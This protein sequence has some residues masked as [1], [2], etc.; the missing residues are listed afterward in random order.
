MP[1]RRIA[2]SLTFLFYFSC[3]S[4]AGELRKLGINDLSWGPYN[5]TWTSPGG[6]T[7]TY[8]PR[9]YDNNAFADGLTLYGNDLITKG[10]RAD[11]RAYG[12]GLSTTNGTD[13]WTTAIQNAIDSGVKE[14]YVPDGI[15]S[16]SGINI[17]GKNG[18]KFYGNGK[19]SEIRWAGA[20]N[21][22]MLLIK[23]S[24]RVIVEDLWF[25]NTTDNDPSA[26]IESQIESTTIPAAVN[27]VTKNI[28]SRLTLGGTGANNIYRGIYYTYTAVDQNNDQATIYDVIARNYTV[29]GFSVQNNFTQSAGHRFWNCQFGPGPVAVEMAGSAPGGFTWIGGVT[30]NHTTAAFNIGAYLWP[31]TIDGLISE[32]DERLLVTA[33]SGPMPVIVRNVSYDA[34]SINADNVMISFQGSGP[35]ILE[36]NQ[37]GGYATGIIPLVVMHNS[38]SYSLSKLISIGNIWQIGTGASV[39]SPFTLDDVTQQSLISLGDMMAPVA[40]QVAEALPTVISGLTGITGAAG[41]KP[42]NLRGTFTVDNTAT[43]GV[44]TFG[45]AETN[46]S[47]YL[48]VVPTDNTGAVAAGSNRVSNIAKTANGFTITVETAPGAGTT[49]RFDWFLI[50]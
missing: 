34:S 38:G 33:T 6:A 37:F 20:D 35:L 48:S 29:A 39:S 13:N 31:F 3:L 42:N 19:S 5:T 14:V 23:N 45:T 17:T 16:I 24:E 40:T 43:T 4:W 36:G 32:F 26:C 46:A 1:R 49:Q 50:R 10:P 41:P 11:V 21:V 28:F 47:Y 12:A 2:L 7:V 22:P 30:F 15:F 18:F 9:Y 44:V 27:G 8:F 25:N